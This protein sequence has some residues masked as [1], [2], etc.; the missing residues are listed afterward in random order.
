ME[1]QNSPPPR[2]LSQIVHICCIQYA[3]KAEQFIPEEGV[4]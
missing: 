1:K 2:T 3:K 4:L